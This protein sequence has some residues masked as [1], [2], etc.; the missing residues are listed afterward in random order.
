MTLRCDCY[1]GSGDRQCTRENAA[2]DARDAR[3]VVVT[4]MEG[5]AGF[6]DMCPD[7]RAAASFNQ[8]R[9]SEQHLRDREDENRGTPEHPRQHT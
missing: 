9:E 1:R 4:V 5:G 7:A 6:F 8:R 2:S 3:L